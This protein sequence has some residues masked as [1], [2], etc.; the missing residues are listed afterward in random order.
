M[1]QNRRNLPTDTQIRERIALRAF[2]I[3]QD[4]GCQHGR[5]LDDWLQAETEVLSGKEQ[6]EKRFSTGKPSS[7]TRSPEAPRNAPKTKKT[8]AG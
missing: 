1:E 7:T 6:Q 8:A 2:Q 4:R 3:Y 5:D